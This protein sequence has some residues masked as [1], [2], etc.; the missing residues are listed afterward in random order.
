MKREEIST[1]LDCKGRK[2]CWKCGRNSKSCWDCQE[3][4][5]FLSQLSCKQL[6][7]A[8]NKILHNNAVS[9]KSWQRRTCELLTFI[10]FFINEYFNFFRGWLVGMADEKSEG[11]MERAVEWIWVGWLVPHTF[12]CPS[13]GLL[14][15]SPILSHFVKVGGYSTL[16]TLVLIFNLLILF[17]VAKNKYLH[18]TTHYVM[19][20]LALR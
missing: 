15:F 16:S 6:M 19:V 3:A 9:K 13:L 20:T 14:V 5:K 12:Y 8:R 10:N 7:L 2:F 4:W 11:D 18:Y 17:S 1:Y